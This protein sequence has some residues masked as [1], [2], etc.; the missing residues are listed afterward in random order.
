MH[1]HIRG[2]RAIRLPVAMLVKRLVHHRAADAVSSRIRDVITPGTATKLAA[3]SALKLDHRVIV[4][5]D[6]GVV[7][8]RQLEG[9]RIVVVEACRDCGGR[10]GGFRL[11]QSC[12]LTVRPF[13][14]NPSSG[15]R[16]R[17]KE[18]E[19]EFDPRKR[20]AEGAFRSAV[21]AD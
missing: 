1:D 10:H 20:H 12:G 14:G 18:E 13:L 8:T 9:L 11:V 4:R 5:I 6:D 7:L 15:R 21:L 2:Q 17:S 19:K 16:K 3:V